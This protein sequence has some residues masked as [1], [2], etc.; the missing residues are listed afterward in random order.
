LVKPC[1]EIASVYRVWQEYDTAIEGTASGA[2]KGRNIDDA[3]GGT[4]EGKAFAAA[5]GAGIGAII[6]T[7]IGASRKESKL[8]VLIYSK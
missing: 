6:G 3:I 8:R 2:R 1:N 4:S 7:I 5:F